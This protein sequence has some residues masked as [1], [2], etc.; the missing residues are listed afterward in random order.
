LDPA[1]PASEV[2]EEQERV[3][4]DIN[5]FVKDLVKEKFTTSC[6]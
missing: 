1:L 4:W 5:T 6:G 2:E 3:L